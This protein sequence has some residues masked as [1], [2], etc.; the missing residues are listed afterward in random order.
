[1]S[2]E[3][4]NYHLTMTF[5]VP[6]YVKHDMLAT[7][8]ETKRTTNIEKGRE[9]VRELNREDRYSRWVLLT[10]EVPCEITDLEVVE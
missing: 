9:F 10:V 3:Y 5:Y 6:G 4:K 7:T 1:M 8:D 2:I